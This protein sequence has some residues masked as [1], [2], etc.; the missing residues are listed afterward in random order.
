VGIDLK[1]EIDILRNKVYET[2]LRM[3]RAGLVVAKEGNVSGR[4][5]GEEKIAIT[6]SQL[7]Y[8]VMTP[9]DVLVVDFDENVIVGKLDPS[10]ETKMHLAVYKARSEVGGVMHTHSPYATALSCIHGKIPPLLDEQTVFLGGDVE[11]TTY[12]MSGTPE[13][14]SNAAQALRD[15][16]ATLLANHGTICCGRT[17]DEALRNAIL[18]EKLAQ[19][20]GI[21]KTMGEVALVPPGVVELQKQ[22]YQFKRQ[23]RV[24]NSPS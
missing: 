13:I 12:A 21:A 8:E 9:E 17:L 4:L 23:E 20:Y 2:A 3:V 22:Y 15:R 1:S 16:D 10:I 7:P 11:T 6:P 24:K 19:V 5:S 14:A 18:V